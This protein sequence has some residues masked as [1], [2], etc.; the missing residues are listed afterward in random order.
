MIKRSLLVCGVALLAWHFAAPRLTK[1]FYTIPGQQRANY[2]H[3]QNYVQDAKAE[4][5]VIVGS[6]MSERMDERILGSSHVKLT[7]PG[8]GP[9]TGLEIVN[10]SG[11]RPPVVWIETNVLL[12]APEQDLIKDALTPWRVELR[13]ISPVFK[14]A[15]RP[16]EFGVGFLKAVVDKGSKALAR[17]PATADAPAA[18]LDDAVFEGMMKANREALSKVPSPEL[19]KERVDALAKHV[20]ELSKSGTKCVFFE[21]PIEPSLQNLAEPAAVRN[22]LKQRFPESDYAWMSLDRGTPWQTTDGIHLTPPEAEQVIQRI[23]EFE[24]GL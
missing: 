5:H 12:R 18:G 1:K 6:S 23:K 13:K 8:G 9:L 21:M 22:A 19:L 3:A 10:R 17:K 15:Y 14:E 4:T 16:S 7:F 11:K 20:E 24:K 2:L